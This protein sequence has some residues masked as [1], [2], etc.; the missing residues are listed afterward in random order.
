[1]EH[2]QK[3]VTDR[4]D[5]DT[6]IK[7]YWSGDFMAN[8]SVL[9]AG[10]EGRVSLLYTPRNGVSVR[11]CDL[12]TEYREGVDYLLSGNTLTRL[13]GSSMPYFT[14]EELYPREEV[15]HSRAGKTTER[16][17]VLFGEGS[18]IAQHQVFVSYFHE[19]A[20]EGI[21]PEDQSRKLPRT[22]ERLERGEPLKLLF[23]GDSI[24]T[25][26]NS[27][28]KIGFEPFAD[29]W[30]I[31]VKKGLE[32][33]YPKASID[34][35]NTA[36]GGKKTAWGLETLEENLL[37]YQPN[38]VILAFGMNDRELTPEEHVAEIKELIERTQAALPA[39]EIALVATMLPNAETFKFW[40]EQYTFEDAYG[41]LLLP[42]HPELSLV[43]MTSVH[44]AL[45]KKKQYRDMTGNNVN[46]PNDFLARAYAHSILRVMTGK[47]L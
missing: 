2:P 16:P 30:P 28:G 39:V 36:V 19:D 46:H 26:A 12:K 42:S 34:Y 35:V 10:E 20:W 6:Y 7:P 5:F 27:S 4:Y 31:L 43:P 9:F 15:E 24:T 18:W 29:P 11:S 22:L 17:W 41:R 44:A 37:V 45:L 23:F 40:K 47:E 8:E 13:A 32:K 14:D 3:Y 1:M 21:I 33:L 38:T 25:G